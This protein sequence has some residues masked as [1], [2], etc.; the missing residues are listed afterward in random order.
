MNNNVPIQLTQFIGRQREIADV[1]RLLA[2]TRLL[3]LIGPAGCGKTRL[4]LRMAQEVNERYPDGAH[5]VELAPLADPTLLSQTIA[6]KLD[7]KEQ[8]GRPPLA[9]IIDALANKELLLVLDNCEHLLST[10][11]HLV[12]ALLAETTIS[13]LATSREPLRVPGERLYPVPP[14]SL[15]PPD[16]TLDDIDELSQFDAVQLFVERARAILPPFALT[17]ANATTV[18]T[19]CRQ[20]DGNP[21]A[22]E[23]ATARVNVLTAEQIAARLDSRFALLRTADHIIYSPHKSLRAAIDWSYE[24]LTPAEQTLLLRLSV[25]AGGCSLNTAETVCTGRGIEREQ[26]LDLLASLVNKSLVTAVTLQRSEARY[27]LL[28]TIRQYG[29]E[30][31]KEAGDLSRLK[32][33]HL[34]CFLELTE[35]AAAKLTGQHQER[36]LN[37]LEDE[38]DNVRAALSWSLASGSIEAGL[39]IANALYQFW[40][41][42]DY[43]EEA[44]TWLERLLAGAD[45]PVPVEVRAQALCYAVNMAHFRGNHVARKAFGHEIA[46]LAD[47]LSPQDKQA[48]V[49]TSAAQGFSERLEGDHESAFALARQQIQLHRELE[50][51]YELGVALTISSFV[52]M[53]LDKYDEARAMLDEGLPLLRDFGNPYRIA[54][55]LNF[56]GDL[57]RCERNYERAQSAYEESVSLLREIDAV[58]D[59]ASALHNLGHTCL[60]LGDTERAETLFDESLALHQEQGNRPGMTECLLGFA[61]LAVVT[62]LPAEG[63]RLLA[64]AA[65]IGG[66]SITSEWAATALEYEHYRELARA[67]VGETAFQEEQAAGQRMSLEQAVDLAETVAQKAAAARQV[68]RQLEQLTPRER[69]VATLIGRAKSNGEIAAELVVGK[70]TVESHVANIRSK[71]GF[72]ERA[73]IVRWTIAAGLV[74]AAG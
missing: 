15:P 48:L 4:A 65:A 64:A 3:T 27:S 46:I 6:I 24:L 31:L 70:R 33:R 10:C 20:L 37:W 45:E 34:Q 73:Q 41:I 61:A 68:G 28:E 62:D 8:P 35:E 9:G 67:G 21:L 52:A 69:E 43:A 60:H 19:I 40:T 58:R 25:F 47:T 71:L 56:S 29:Q 2:D 39:R 1:R 42:R 49:W 16:Q 54:M 57:A 53:S 55:A 51:T 66:R 5:L 36:W 74:K 38:Y 50:D 13:I 11:A 32:D 72:T 22:I 63:A 59:L 44:L 23:M 17:S 12:S 14:L 18:A 30:K 7:V 26:I